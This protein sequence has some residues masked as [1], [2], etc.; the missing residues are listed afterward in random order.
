[1]SSGEERDL[2]QAMLRLW[3]KDAAEVADDYAQQYRLIGNETAA[4]RW[5]NVGHLIVDA[6]SPPVRPNS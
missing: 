4:S 5:H 6:L 1:M 2:S 3:G